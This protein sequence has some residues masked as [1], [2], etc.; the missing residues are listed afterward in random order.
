MPHAALFVVQDLLILLNSINYPRFNAAR[1]FVC[2][3]SINSEARGKVN[4]VSMPHAA[5]FVVQVYLVV[6]VLRCLSRFNAA[7]GFVCGASLQEA[8]KLMESV[9]FNAARGFVCGARLIW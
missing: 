4:E 9:R 2:G 8:G 7:R 6:I 5:L 3:A 1:G